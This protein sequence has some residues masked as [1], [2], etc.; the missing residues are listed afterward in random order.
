MPWP[1][2]TPFAHRLPRVVCNNVEMPQAKRLR[3]SSTLAAGVRSCSSDRAGSSNRWK[4][5]SREACMARCCRRERAYGHNIPWHPVP[6]P[7]CPTPCM[8]AA[9]LLLSS[10]FP[11][12]PGQSYKDACHSR[13]QPLPASDKIQTSPITPSHCSSFLPAGLSSSSASRSTSL[14]RGRV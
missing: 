4:M 3:A 7:P 1:S 2:I 12:H 6:P 14:A 10:L 5:Q 8:V 11:A 9:L 13:M